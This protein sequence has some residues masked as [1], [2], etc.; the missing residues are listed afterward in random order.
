MIIRSFLSARRMRLGLRHVLLGQI[1]HASSSRLVA[2][3]RKCLREAAPCISFV[4]LA[5][6]AS[7]VQAQSVA[8]SGAPTTTTTKQTQASAHQAERVIYRQGTENKTLEGRV[9]VA[10]ADGGLL[11]Q[12]DDGM[13]WT[14]EG[15]HLID[16]Q[17][18]DKPFKAA[19]QAE[20]ATRLTGELPPGF[21][22]LTT[23]HY[24]IG[25]DTSR[26]YAQWAGSLFERL[27][28]AFTNY[29]EGKGLP[30]RD[31]EFPLV[32]LIFS[33]HGSY[34]QA[35]REDLPGGVGNIIGYYSLRTNRVNM[36]DLTGAEALRGQERRRG[37]LRDI[38]QM[39]SQPA[40][41]PLVSTVVHEATHQIAFNC[42]LQQR[43]ADLPLWLLEGMAVYFEAPDLASARGWTGIGNVNYPRLETFRRNLP[44]WNEGTLESLLADDRRLRDP[45][46]SVDAYADAWALN[47]YLIKFQ[48]KSYAEY[49]KHLAA[50]PPLIEST[51]QERLAE[52]R[53]HFGDLKQLELDFLKRMARVE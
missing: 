31:P 33:E 48:S 41:V 51:P 10:A 5:M 19:T 3:S 38:N 1:V 20:M 53:R 4:L 16:R 37:S 45:R 25:Y 30:L 11:L 47:Y 17:A 42:G 32:V 50:K 14:I 13:L 7:Y 6:G 34:D 18:S 52:F 27:H 2:I 8:P 22:V 46:A 28:R 24:V 49:L 9:I 43:Y 15:P 29:W 39:L 23:Q 36:F 44:K 26:V 40:A 12:S 21:N 35:S